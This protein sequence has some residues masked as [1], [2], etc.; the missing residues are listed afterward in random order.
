MK[1]RV[2]PF[3]PFAFLF[4]FDENPNHGSGLY[5][6]LRSSKSSVVPPP[7]LMLSSSIHVLFH[8]ISKQLQRVVCFCFFGA[9]CGS[10]LP[11]HTRVFPP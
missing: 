2:P 3:S 4:A 1:V 5:P 8:F 6:I 11:R 9:L 10:S 7:S